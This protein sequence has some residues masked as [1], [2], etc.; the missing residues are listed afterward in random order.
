LHISHQSS[1]KIQRRLV[2]TSGLV[3]STAILLIG[4]QTILGYSI[5][6]LTATMMIC[7]G[8][9]LI[10]SIVFALAFLN[11]LKKRKATFI[12]KEF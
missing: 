12:E 7:Y 3:W 10:W 2:H 4:L 5:F 11:V 1:E 8:F 9:L 6:E